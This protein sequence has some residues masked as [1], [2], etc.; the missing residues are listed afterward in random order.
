MTAFTL[1]L[2]CLLRAMALVFSGLLA[3]AQLGLRK[4]TT[5]QVFVVASSA[6]VQ[7]GPR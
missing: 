7:S 4:S 5:A 6:T 1:S 2:L 3:I